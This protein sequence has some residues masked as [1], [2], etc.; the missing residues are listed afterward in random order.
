MKLPQSSKAELRRLATE[1]LKT[2]RR[3]RK[4]KILHILPEG[5][6][7]ALRDKNGEIIEWNG[8]VSFK[9]LGKRAI[10]RKA[11]LAKMHF[12]YMRAMG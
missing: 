3:K 5:D 9:K 10:F 1:A 7:G 6:T 12:R 2:A 11:H 8:R 4:N